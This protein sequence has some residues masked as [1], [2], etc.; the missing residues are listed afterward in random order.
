MLSLYGLVRRDL[1][2]KGILP[3]RFKEPAKEY[4][5]LRT[6]DGLNLCDSEGKKLFVL[7]Q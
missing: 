5:Q 2:I 7:A 6:A 3:E 1:E 4:V